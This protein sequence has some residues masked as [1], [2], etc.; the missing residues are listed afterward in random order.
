MFLKYSDLVSRGGLRGLAADSVLYGGSRALA[1]GFALLTFPL[2]AR[3]LTKEELGQYTII[4]TLALLLL[5][6]ASLGQDIT[7]MKFLSDDEKG[8]NDADVNVTAIVMQVFGIFVSVLLACAIAVVFS[9]RVTE[10][11]GWG[12]FAMALVSIPATVLFFS[13]LNLSKARFFRGTFL[14]VSLLQVVLFTTFLICSLIILRYGVYGY[15]LSTAGS[16]LLAS[17]VG[18]YLMRGQFFG[19][20]V[21]RRSGRAMLRFAAPYVLGGLLF[22]LLL[23]LDRLVLSWR[24]SAAD[25]GVY[26]V[27]LRYASVMEMTLV[28]FKMAWWPFAFSSYRSSGDSGLF[29]RTL[30]AYVVGAGCFAVVLYA[31]SGFGINLLAGEAYEGALVYILPLLLAELLRGF[32]GMGV[33]IAISGRSFWAPVGVFVGA[34]AGLVA[35]LA[36]WQPLGI[37]SVAW[38]VV[39]GEL[40]AFVVTA[41]ISQRFLVLR[42]QFGKALFLASILLLYL[43]SSEAGLIST[44]PLQTLVFLLIY[45]AIGWYVLRSSRAPGPQAVDEAVAAQKGGHPIE[46]LVDGAVPGNRT[47]HSEQERAAGPDEDPQAPKDPARGQ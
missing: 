34:A 3:I 16:L 31:L 28:G 40:V 13:V 27:A 43:S 17:V 47:A 24:A 4:Q 37:V 35:I 12:L 11:L 41:T 14:A 46:D 42:W 45:C 38:G 18:L 2:V 20:R 32:Q 6:L 8:F 21:S 44:R 30:I 26:S 29:G 7:V 19:G 25:I 15:A 9:S 23:F 36:L 1:A 5:P 39:V 33:G 22:V 10:I